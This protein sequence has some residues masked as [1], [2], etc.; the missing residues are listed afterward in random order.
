MGRLG[1]FRYIFW[2]VLL[3]VLGLVGYALVSDLPAP[4]RE[5]SVPI[6]V[7]GGEV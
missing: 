5:V 1:V 6:R 2:L 7:S 3:G 4:V